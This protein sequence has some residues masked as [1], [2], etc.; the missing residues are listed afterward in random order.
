[1]GECAG[2]SEVCNSFATPLCV[3]AREVDTRRDVES[4]PETEEAGMEMESGI[5]FEDEEISAR[6]LGLRLS[7]SEAESAIA[8]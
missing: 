8:N 1:M 7:T 5:K 4:G 2:E 6:G 3:R